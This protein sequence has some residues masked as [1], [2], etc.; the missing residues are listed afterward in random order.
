MSRSVA[1]AFAAVVAIGAAVTAFSVGVNAQAD[2]PVRVEVENATGM[3]MTA[4]YLA[5]AAGGPE[6]DVLDRDAARPGETVV[7]A[8]K[9]DARPCAHDVTAEFSD[10]ETIELTGI[11]LCA[12]DASLVIHE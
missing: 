5:P 7:V 6:R 2:A 1:A 9:G 4:L 3:V 8:L 11:D 12:A 10:G